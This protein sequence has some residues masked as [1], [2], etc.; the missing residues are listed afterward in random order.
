MN[1]IFF[2]VFVLQIYRRGLG[3]GEPSRGAEDEKGERKERKGRREEK[4]KGSCC[5]LLDRKTLPSLSRPKSII[6]R[7]QSWRNPSRSGTPRGGAYGKNVNE[8]RTKGWARSFWVLRN[9]DRSV[10][11][12]GNL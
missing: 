6:K 7:L 10:K 4:E 12:G 2:K 11:N 5:K 3:A 8:N 1:G 9:P